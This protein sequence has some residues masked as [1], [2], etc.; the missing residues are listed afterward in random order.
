MV[1]LADGAL[2]Q[3]L[4]ALVAINAEYAKALS[5][6]NPG[7]LVPALQMGGSG[8]SSG[9]ALDFIKLLTAKAAKDLSLDMKVKQQ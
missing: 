1:F 7:A 6:A 5:T 4:E 8:G 9:G 2:A 3:M